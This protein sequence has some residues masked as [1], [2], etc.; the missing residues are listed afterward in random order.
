MAGV[1]T[2]KN[3]GLEGLVESKIFFQ[4]VSMFRDCLQNLQKTLCT[5]SVSFRKPL[6]SVPL[7]LVHTTVKA[8]DCL[9][10][11]FINNNHCNNFNSSVIYNNHTHY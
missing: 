10:H 8:R 7:K 5:D 11:D 9:N 2:V 4:L 1:A 6:H 3:L